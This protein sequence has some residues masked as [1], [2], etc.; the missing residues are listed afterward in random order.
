[1]GAIIA[2]MM[3]EKRILMSVDRR[4]INCD[5]VLLCGIWKDLR[6]KECGY[7]YDDEERRQRADKVEFSLQ[8]GVGVKQGML[9]DCDM[10]LS[11]L[12]YLGV[13]LTLLFALHTIR[14][15]AGCMFRLIRP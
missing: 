10:R 2:A 14:R 12:G 6:V 3:V 1:M 4:N 11:S 9:G 5:I 8:G 13:E 15:L 7:C